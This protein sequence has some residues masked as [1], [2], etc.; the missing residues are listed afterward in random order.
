MDWNALWEL[1]KAAGPAGVGVGLLVLGFV[2]FGTFTDVFKTGT[3]KRL[4]AMAS[5]LLFAGVKPGDVESAVVAALGLCVATGL[6][7]LVDAIIK[8][9][10]ERKK[11]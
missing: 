10:A 5:T 2:Y 3:L 7:L 4:A 8:I 6:K 11:K 1:L 9:V